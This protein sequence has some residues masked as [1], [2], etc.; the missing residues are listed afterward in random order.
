VSRSATIVVSYLV[1]ACGW[2]LP[3][4][5]AH[6]QRHREVVDINRGFYRQLLQLDARLH[7]SA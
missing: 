5:Y 4:A 6:V 2:R 7:D 1:G 3:A